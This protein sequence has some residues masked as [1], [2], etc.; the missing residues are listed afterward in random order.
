MMMTETTT[1]AFR[2]WSA[3]LDSGTLTAS[4]CRGFASTVFRLAMDADGF[5]RH[6][7]RGRRRTNLTPAE[8]EVLV[9][10]IGAMGGVRL[11]DEQ[12]AAGLG[13]L[14]RYGAAASVWWGRTFPVERLDSFSHFTFHGDAI[15]PDDRGWSSVPLYRVHFTDG[16]PT[17]DYWRRA[18]QSG[19]GAEWWPTVAS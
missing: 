9:T 11:T 3:R 18:W 17:I 4:E 19:G 5:E 6:A 14:R 15:D 12:T 7:P 13:W 1:P 10:R 8:A 2:R 16:G